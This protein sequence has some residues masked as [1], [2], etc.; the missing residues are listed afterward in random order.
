MDLYIKILN[1]CL[2]RSLNFNSF[3]FENKVYVCDVYCDFVIILIAL[4]YS[5]FILKNELCMYLT[6]TGHNIA[7][8]IIL[9]NSIK[10]SWCTMG[11]NILI[12]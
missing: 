7:D 6:T 9:M 11:E 1:G 10:S 5:I 12:Y 3:N 2:Y 8:E 4:F